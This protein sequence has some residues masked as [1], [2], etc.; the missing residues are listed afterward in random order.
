MPMFEYECPQGHVDEH[1]RKYADR[2]IPV[3]CLPCGETMTRIEISHGHVPPS[4]VYS[5]APNIG[6]ANQFERR[7]QALKDGVKVIPKI[8][9]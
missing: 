9:D 4:G 1:I 2:D 3:F 6:S 8:N 7:Q 5:Y